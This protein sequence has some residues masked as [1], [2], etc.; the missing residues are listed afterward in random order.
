M[1]LTFLGTGAAICIKTPDSE[2]K[3]EQRRCSSM[4]I[5]N[6]ILID[7]PFQAFDRA[8]AL[9]VDTSAVTDVFLTHSHC[10]HFIKE[11][12]LRFA[13]GAK[14]KNQVLFAFFFKNFA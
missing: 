6:N 4:L 9:G 11:V 3:G 12:L 14:T 10:D 13:D 1:K 2:I 8:T 7:V 5:D